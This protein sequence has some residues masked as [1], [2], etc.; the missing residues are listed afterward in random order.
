MHSTPDNVVDVDMQCNIY[1][2]CTH[3]TN[4]RNMCIY[5]QYQY[6][7]VC[8]VYR[9]MWSWSRDWRTLH[10]C[11][12]VLPALM[13]SHDTCLIT[14]T[15]LFPRFS[16]AILPEVDGKEVSGAGAAEHRSNGGRAPDALRLKGGTA[17]QIGERG[18]KGGP[19]VRRRG[20]KG[21]FV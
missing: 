2:Y 17:T 10:S 14:T 5:V 13:L 18:G 1:T 15:R 19:W 11:S 7:H 3:C 21:H 16:L 20:V 9:T 8:S 12:A 4:E 6:M